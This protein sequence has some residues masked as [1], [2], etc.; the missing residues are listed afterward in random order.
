MCHLNA[1]RTTPHQP[2]LC[3]LCSLPLTIYATPKV[4]HCNGH[5]LLFLHT[6]DIVDYCVELVFA[7]HYCVVVFTIILCTDS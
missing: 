6:G 2:V 1:P 4:C 7:L 3:M 5:T